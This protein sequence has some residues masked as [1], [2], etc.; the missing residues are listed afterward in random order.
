[1]AHLTVTPG[2]LGTSLALAQTH[3]SR[4]SHT[5]PTTARFLFGRILMAL[6]CTCS[7]AGCGGGSSSGSNSGGTQNPSQLAVW[8]NSLNGIQFTMVGTD[9]SIPGAGTTNIPVEII[10]VS[11]NFS[12]A[13][14]IISPEGPACGDTQSVVARV[15]NS[16]LFT[17]NPWVDV[18]G[19]IPIGNTQF[20]DAFQRMNFWTWTGSVSP[21]YH[22]MLQPVSVQQT[23]SIDVPPNIGAILTPS[24]TCPS[25]M[26]GAIPSSLMNSMIP[27]V[28]SNQNITPNTL[29]IFLTYDISF[30]P[31]NFLGYHNVMGNQSFI[32]ASYIDAGFNDPTVVASDVAVL[33]HEV[34]EW[35][36]NPLGENIVPPWGGF[37]IQPG[38]S[39]QLEVGDPLS[40]NIFALPPTA[41]FTYHVQELAFVSWF[42]RDAP[43]VSINGQYSSLG[44][45]GSPAPLCQ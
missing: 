34:G 15:V 6:C 1:M 43:S 37:G 18:T 36:N 17:S 35:I 11:L 7:F 13:G 28:L 4:R 26:I 3:C 12:A 21:G 32:V 19:T 33:S 29:P 40:R 22:V 25:Q 2:R 31:E 44:T 45:F 23:V 5:R 38:C 39:N 24:P 9:P 16:P 30:V 42:T 14:I 27:T 20:G 10:P 41:D 8:T